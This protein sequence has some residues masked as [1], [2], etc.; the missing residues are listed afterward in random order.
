[1]WADINT[2][3]VQ[4]NLFRIFRSEMI[5]VA[6]DYENDAERKFAHH[7]LL[8]KVEA[9]MVSQQYGDLLEKI[10]VAVPKNKGTL[11]GKKNK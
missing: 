5:G 10:G 3:P 9:E 6:V 8:P 11:Q 1:M 2:K 7:I 4:G